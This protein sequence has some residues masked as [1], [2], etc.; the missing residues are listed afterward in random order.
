M[1]DQTMLNV[2]VRLDRLERENRRLKVLGALAAVV[3]FFILL[4]ADTPFRTIKIV[5]KVGNER[6]LLIDGDNKKFA[7]DSLSLNIYPWLRS[8]A[9]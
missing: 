3:L 1:N 2:L 8:V 7:E 6:F 9:R 4:I 5:N